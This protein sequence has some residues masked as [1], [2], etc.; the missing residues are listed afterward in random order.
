M[1]YMYLDRDDSSCVF[2]QG[3]CTPDYG[4]T[5][6]D[7][8]YSAWIS[9]QSRGTYAVAVMDDFGGNSGRS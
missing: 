7:G 2:L 6:S 9:G 3:C 5:G 1:V 8:T 4:T